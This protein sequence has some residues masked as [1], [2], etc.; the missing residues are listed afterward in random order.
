MQGFGIPIVASPV[1]SLLEAD[2][3]TISNNSSDTANDLDFSAGR[4]VLQN[5]AG[6]RRVVVFPAPIT[7]QIDASWALGTNQGGLD[8]GSVADG[9]YHAFVIFNSVS[10][11]TNAIFSNSLTPTLPVG[12]GWWRRVGS[13][14]RV[15]SVNRSFAQFGRYFQ[16]ATRIRALDNYAVST[17]GELIVLPVPTGLSVRAH[18][19]LSLGGGPADSSNLL[20]LV[21]G[22]NLTGTIPD[23]RPTLGTFGAT[24]GHR[25][26]AS[27]SGIA[28]G[29]GTVS[30]IVRTTNTSG[31]LYFRRSG[32]YQS[33]SAQT[34]FQ[35]HGYEDVLL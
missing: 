2:R 31:Q 32:T 11:L 33:G 10:G 16:F 9:T 6:D 24:V 4:S 13:F 26:D 3:I 22:G 19:T 12:F 35:I 20:V 28:T 27:Y 23:A 34:T 29:G 1:L 8:A 14:T 7:K 25:R 21:L 30:E 15:S 5:A 18:G 17:S